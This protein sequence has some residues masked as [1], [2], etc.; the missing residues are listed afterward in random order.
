VKP[1]A[2]MMGS[3]RAASLCDDPAVA[4][5]EV[6]EGWDR[7]RRLLLS[8]YERVALRLFADRGF[9][10]VTVEDVAAAAGVSARTLFRYFP[11]KED[12]LLGFPRRGVAAVVE[13][14]RGLEP[15]DAPLDA[16]WELRL[17]SIDAEV[18]D[19]ELLA[20]WRKAAVDAEDV[21]ATV[22]GE[23]IQFLME[24][25]TEYCARSL[26]VDPARDVRPRLMAGIA[27]GAE[28]ALVEMIT[29]SDLSLV[30][31]AEQAA[32]VMNEV[33]GGGGSGRERRARP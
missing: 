14:I 28:L 13:R 3:A 16:L 10:S 24:A 9:R 2:S 20:L 4:E 7:R 32:D 27:A 25:M 29:R 33:R 26:G 15:C 18:P 22:R 6:S 12:F 8:R 1:A 21:V 11:T 5:T 17:G 19:V 30:E 31:I 23:R